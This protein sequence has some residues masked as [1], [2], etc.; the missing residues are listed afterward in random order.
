MSYLYFNELNTEL[1]TRRWEV[2]SVAQETVLGHVRFWSAWRKYVF[3]P[4]DRTLYDADCLQEITD[5]CQE[6]TRVWRN[7]VQARK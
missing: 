2:M 3:A 7:E 6:Q 1:K 4:H 5:F